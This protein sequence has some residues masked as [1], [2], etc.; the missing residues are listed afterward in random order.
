MILT[1][2][3]N[4]QRG[5]MIVVVIMLLALL[6][7]IGIAG[8]TVS[9]TEQQTAASEQFY[10]MALFSAEAGGSYVM[11]NTDLYHGANVTPGGSLSFPDTADA[12]VTHNLGELQSFNGTVEYLGSSS[13]PRESGYEV[14]TYRSHIYRID[15]NGY[16]PRDSQILIEEGFYRIGF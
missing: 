11:K 8:I 16:G 10:K 14:G 9:N 4:N 3:I 6:T 2:Q 15:S 13:P 5:S 1:R 7:I 12:S